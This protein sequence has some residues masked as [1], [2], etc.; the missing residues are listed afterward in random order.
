[1]IKKCI[2]L[3]DGSLMTASIDYGAHIYPVNVSTCN[4]SNVDIPVFTTVA[5]TTRMVWPRRYR[6]LLSRHVHIFC[7]STILPS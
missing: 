1:M 3:R 2:F 7:I 5:T 6:E 4:V